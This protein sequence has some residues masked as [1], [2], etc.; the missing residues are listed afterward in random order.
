MTRSER[1][2]EA[3]LEMMSVERGAAV[4]TLEAYR[5]DLSHFLDVL[6]GLGCSYLTAG[7]QDVERYF[8]AVHEDGLAPSTAAR[9]LSSIRQFY[10]FLYG[11]GLVATDP[12][13]LVPAPRRGPALPR[14]VSEAEVAALLSH[15]AKDASPQGLRLNCLLELLYATGL[16]VSEVV[17]L[18]LAA[19]AGAPRTMMVKGKGGRE[20]VVP[21]NDASRAALA[22]YL[23]VRPDFLKKAGPSLR[24]SRYLFPSRGG[25]G[26]L[27][28]HRLAQLLKEAAAAA[29][30]SPQRLSPHTLRHAFASH[31][32]AHGAD[33]RSVQQMLGHADISTT[34]IYTHVQEERLKSAVATHHPLARKGDTAS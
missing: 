15:V 23:E 17:S 34:Q 25:S 30:I 26:H 6:S 32:I 3:F 1:H 16:R 4:K 24:T 13:V 10:K 28:R 12:S 8:E 27:T 20:R 7:R 33:L 29:G 9:R 14:T 21:L 11:E 5:R 22:A 31:L 2:V 18:P 19:A